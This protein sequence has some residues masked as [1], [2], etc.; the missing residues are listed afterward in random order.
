MVTGF[1]S[2]WYWLAMFVLWAMLITGIIVFMVRRVGEPRTDREICDPHAILRI[3]YARG[4]IS[5][6]E[7]EAKKKDLEG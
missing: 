1:D 6:E 3:R 7:F 2:F 4:E 5:K